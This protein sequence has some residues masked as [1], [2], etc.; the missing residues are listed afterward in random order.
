MCT[1]F[2]GNCVRLEVIDVTENPDEAEREKIL[3]TPTLIRQL[4]EPTRRLVGDMGDPHRLIQLLGLK[5]YIR[6]RNP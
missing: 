5:E 3:A 1:E 4:P 6:P 2:L